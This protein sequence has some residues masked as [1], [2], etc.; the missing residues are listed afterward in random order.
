MADITMCICNSCPVS[1][2]CYRVKAKSDPYQSY[3]NFEYECNENN[4][5]ADFIRYER[6]ENI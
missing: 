6:G 3:C 1:E 5:F 4:G 2:Q